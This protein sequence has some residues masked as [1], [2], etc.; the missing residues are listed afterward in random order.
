MREKV[1]PQADTLQQLL[2]NERLQQRMTGRVI[3]VDE[4][5]LVST[6]QMRYL[7]RIAQLHQ[8]RLILV[9]D[10]KQHT[11]V[12]AGDALR[13]LQEYGGVEAARLTE[14][15]RQRD[16]FLRRAVKLLAKK[17][18]WQ[19]FGGF[20]RQGAVKEIRE[21][22]KLL[23]AAS[24]DYVRTLREK[25]SCLVISPVWSDIHRFTD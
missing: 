18:A 4:A 12:E 9:G 3:I 23:A 15:R 20:Y 24:D 19:A 7:C 6:R 16:P 21:P 8:N 14:I 2:V 13:A 25:K 1:T 10:V 22:G 5:G 17:K 11:S